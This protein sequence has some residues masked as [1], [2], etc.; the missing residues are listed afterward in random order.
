MP[1]RLQAITWISVGL[2]YYHIYASLG[3]NELTAIRIWMINHVQSY[4]TYE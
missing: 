3:F 1:N 2:A 4:V